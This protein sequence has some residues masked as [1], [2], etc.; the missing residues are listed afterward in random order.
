MY[1]CTKTHTHTYRQIEREEG[2]ERERRREGEREREREGEREREDR[3]ALMLGRADR[4]RE[5]EVRS[6]RAESIQI[7][8]HQLHCHTRGIWGEG[9]I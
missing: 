1:A 4:R 5:E 8:I 2:G 3:N 6:G 9:R 7:L